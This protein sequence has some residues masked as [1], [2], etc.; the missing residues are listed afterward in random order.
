MSKT[1]GPVFAKERK[2]RDLYLGS[3]I[4]VMW[5]R[6]LFSSIRSISLFIRGAP[7][8]G[9]RAFQNP[10]PRILQLRTS[11]I[12][13]N[14]FLFIGCRF[15]KRR[16]A[17]GSMSTVYKVELLQICRGHIFEIDS[18]IKILGAAIGWS[19]LSISE[20]IETPISSSVYLERGRIYSFSASINISS[21]CFSWRPIVILG[22]SSLFKYQK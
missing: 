12:E 18:W 11:N 21:T 14:Y 19:R 20:G 17:Y 3:R 22:C 1:E 5:P 6:L 13:A 15:Y 9:T 16:I 2:N 8:G 7:S 4:N 10:V